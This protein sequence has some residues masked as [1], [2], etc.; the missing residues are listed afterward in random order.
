MHCALSLTHSSMFSLDYTWIDHSR[1][2]VKLPAPTYIDYVMTWLQNLLDD[3]TV[4]PTKSGMLSNRCCLCG[5]SVTFLTQGM[6]FSRH[7]HRPP[8]TCTARC[9]ACLHI[10][11]MRTI[12]IYFTYAAN[13]TSIHFL[14]T[15]SHSVG[16]MNCSRSKM[17]RGHPMPPW[18]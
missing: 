13:P 17:S 4:F 2:Q 18:E 9:C 14:R 8:S 3:E 12:A 1:K 11:T 5:G 7:S 6:N 10:Y 15:S 16:N